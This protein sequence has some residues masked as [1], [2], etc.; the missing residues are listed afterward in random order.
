M[1]E[2]QENNNK[3]TSSKIGLKIALGV[4][5]LIAIIAIIVT[6]IL[7]SKGEK[8]STI[9][10]TGLSE[11]K[12][13][14]KESET[15]QI[16]LVDYDGG[17]FTIKI[18]EGWKVE[19]GGADMFYAIRV[20][21]PEDTRY[22][23]FAILKAEPFL[24]NDKAKQWY[25]NYYNSFGGSGNKVLAE[26]IV[27]YK[28]TVEAFYSS[29]NEYAAYTKKVDTIY[30][31]FNFPDLKNF[32]MVESF[33]SNSS[34][35]SVAKDDKTLRGTFQDSK[36][37]KN[38]EGL[39]MA[40]LIDQGSYMALGYDTLFYTMYNVMGITTAQ[41]DLVNYQNILT[42]SL[43]SLVYKDSFTQQTIANGNERTKNALAINASIQEAYNSYN[44]AWSARQKNYDITSQKYSDSTLSYERVYDTE[45]GDIYKA[46]NGFTDDYKGERYKAVTDNMYTEPITG[47]IEKQ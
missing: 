20:Y 23:I 29:F 41:Y 35:K 9:G 43:N 4:V 32:A 1:E 47:Y 8:T 38:G 25:Q 7:L 27:L 26:A 10:S 17:N 40:S 2:K 37:G 18:P 36:T 33:E 3:K 46:Y 6:I 28:P 19:T 13:S 5:G 44:A 34:M 15:N 39:F 22:Q 12:Y 45:T 30:S 14:V 16:K 11:E 21:N 31:T 24:K 42:E